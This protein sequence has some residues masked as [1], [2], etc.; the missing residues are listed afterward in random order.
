MTYLVEFPMA[1]GDT[2]VVEMDDDQL[3]GFAPAAVEPGIVA[4]TATG[5]CTCCKCRPRSSLRGSRCAIRPP[6]APRLPTS[7]HRANC[8]KN[9][10]VVGARRAG[11]GRPCRTKA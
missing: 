4:A 7:G 10:G 3:V 6:C 2:V 11:Y 1:S 9:C 5:M 8:R